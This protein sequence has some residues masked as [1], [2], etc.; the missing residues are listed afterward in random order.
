MP[1]PAC[2][3]FGVPARSFTFRLRNAFYG[4]FDGALSAAEAT[5]LLRAVILQHI[6]PLRQ[7]INP[8]KA[9][10]STTT[11][12]S[13]SLLLAGSKALKRPL[14][15]KPMGHPLGLN[16][17]GVL[18]FRNRA[19]G[20]AA[21]ST[22]LLRATAKASTPFHPHPSIH[23]PL[24]LAGSKVLKRPLVRKPMGHPLGLNPAGVLLFRNR[25]LGGVS[26]AESRVLLRATAKASTPFHTHPS[27]HPSLFAFSY[28]RCCYGPRPKLPPHS[29][30]IHPS[31][32]PSIS[33]FAFSWF[34]GAATALGP[35]TNW[36]PLGRESCWG[37]A[38]SQP[39]PRRCSRIHGAAQGHGQSFHPIPPPS[40]HPSLFAFS[41]F[42]GAETA[43]GPQT[44]GPPLGPESCWG[45][46]VSQ[47]CPRRCFCSR[48]QGAAQGH[49]QSFHPIPYP[50]I[51]PSIHLSLLLA[52]HGAAMGHGQSFHPIPPPS[53]H[54]SIYLSLL[55]AGSKVLKRPLVRRP[56]GHP[57]GVNPAGVLLFRNRALGGVSVAESTVLL[58]AAAKAST[59]H[60]IPLPSI[61]PSIHPSISLLL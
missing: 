31:I 24:L 10:A 19:L 48:I 56:I 3:V 28:P 50:S 5:V 6:N 34:E 57:L 41:W 60:P 29:T 23:L 15:R 44:N 58:R 25:A 22:V 11:H 43:P 37:S 53:I 52:I 40:I 54:P 26:A 39:C 9:K 32:H 51:H 30:P 45:S 7:P 20:G 4:G 55:L 33:P 12:P 21:E 8:S 59:F 42:E 13:I 35:Q 36:P 16:P 47:P 17:A 27:I 46:A 1:W 18:L 2:H 14:V 61:H 38:V 49:G